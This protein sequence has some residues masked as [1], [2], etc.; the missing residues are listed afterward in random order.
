METPGGQDLHPRSC[1]LFQADAEREPRA[2][3]PWAGVWPWEEEEGGETGRESEDEDG[4]KSGYNITGI[5]V[6]PVWE[7]L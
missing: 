7:P 1:R 6:R 5:T 4:G 3:G 2:P